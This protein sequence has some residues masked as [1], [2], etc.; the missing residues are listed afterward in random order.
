M[1]ARAWLRPLLLAAAPAAF[2]A[3]CGAPQDCD[4]SRDRSIFKVAGCVASK[5]GYQARVD[6][7]AEQAD[8]SEAD[9]SAAEA[10][11]RAAEARRDGAGAQAARLRADLATQQT[12]SIALER[13]I[14]DARNRSRIDQ[15]RL[16][17]LEQDIA[18]LRTEQDRLRGAP[19]S[20]QQQQQLQELRRRHD[21][22]DQQWDRLRAATPG[23]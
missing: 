4:P 15:G 16:G 6:H 8:R 7:L 23:S 9:R 2:L 14:R 11:R 12:R 18:N 3:G 19:P 10:D 17:Q 1:T 13:D 5:D 20:P 21:A 22:L